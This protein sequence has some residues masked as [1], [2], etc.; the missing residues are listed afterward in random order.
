M[1]QCALSIAFS[2]SSCP[3]PSGENATSTDPAAGTM[4]GAVPAGA[5]NTLA[6]RKAQVNITGMRMIELAENVGH[7]NVATLRCGP[8]RFH[9]ASGR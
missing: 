8:R 2:T 5:A 6:D 4:T 7:D 1:V 9:H 3:P